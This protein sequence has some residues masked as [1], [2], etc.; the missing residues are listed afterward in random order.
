MCV[1]YT[2]SVIGKFTSGVIFLRINDVSAHMGGGVAFKWKIA[3]LRTISGYFF[4]IT[5][6]LKSASKNRLKIG[7]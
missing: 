3:C 4:Q 5:K 1:S 7:C 6:S 2:S